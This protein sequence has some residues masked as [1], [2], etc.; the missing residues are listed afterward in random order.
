ME[1]QKRIKINLDTNL[2]A[3]SN[4]SVAFDEE[5]FLFTIFSGNQARQFSASPKHAKRLTMLL[6][7]NITDYENKF[8][9]LETKLPEKMETK[10][11]RSMGF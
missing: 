8:G 11:N 10:E 7:K 1:E 9:K 2:Y 4:I 3:I 5:Q 6:E